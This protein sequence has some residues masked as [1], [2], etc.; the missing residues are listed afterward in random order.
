MPTI[1]F[2][3][4]APGPGDVNRFR[5][6]SAL[7]GFSAMAEAG[8]ALTR[9]G[10]R[11]YEMEQQATVAAEKVTAQEAA[12]KWYYDT[13]QKLV[14]LRDTLSQQEQEAR[15]SEEAER[16]LDE[17][18]T[19]ATEEFEGNKVMF[20][21]GRAPLLRQLREDI[22]TTRRTLLVQQSTRSLKN[23][24]ELL[25]TH[26]A[27]DLGTITQEF[28]TL[29]GQAESL[30]AG[31][32]IDEKA[33]NEILGQALM[34]TLEKR[35]EYYLNTFP[36]EASLLIKQDA[37]HFDSLL[38]PIRE[39][40]LKEAAKHGE[41]AY[42]KAV[43]AQL[44]RD[45]VLGLRPF[46]AIRD[47]A[48]QAGLDPLKVEQEWA[49]HQNRHY[50]VAQHIETKNEKAFK[51]QSDE[52]R[53]QFMLTASKN[54]MF[55]VRQ[56]VEENSRNLTGDDARAL[57]E[58]AKSNTK[59]LT[60]PD[61]SDPET[62]R[63]LKRSVYVN[64]NSATTEKAIFAAVQS[65]KLSRG[66]YEQLLDKMYAHRKE[67]KNED[68][69]KRHQA[70][71]EGQLALKKTLTTTSIMEHDPIS[72]QI[73]NKWQDRLLFAQFG[74]EMFAGDQAAFNANPGLF[75][76][77]IQ[78]E[79]KAELDQVNIQEGFRLLGDFPMLI[80]PETGQLDRT[81]VITA[82]QE[83]FL[84]PIDAERILILDR[85]VKEGKV[86]WP[87]KPQPKVE[88]PPPPPDQPWYKKLF[89]GSTESES[90]ESKP[91]SDRKPEKKKNF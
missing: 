1:R 87:Y 21:A 44:K 55:D 47:D 75:I 73:A 42:Q 52:L 11:L 12:D 18:T 15:Y 19:R 69:A 45:I 56:A 86:K 48:L 82:R 90:P 43:D 46:E 28:A 36:V 65:G 76:K 68:T 58:F 70:F 78:A 17:E 23:Q 27:D 32:I 37:Q 61:L 63:D 71:N 25:I 91:K 4:Q 77:K 53:T 79:A 8:N 13:K 22:Y 50:T 9:A 83:K 72:Q 26:S 34:R 64:P 31:F 38:H 67:L 40:Q 30:Q 84:Q 10:L 3:P 85:L 57:L 51:Q 7:S 5:G 16:L 33:K 88:L 2:T 49:E 89:G 35:N 20:G 80:N 62:L 24:A 81:K 6:S 14:T 41:V 39:A 60:A 59:S 54:R 66:D 74:P 29:R